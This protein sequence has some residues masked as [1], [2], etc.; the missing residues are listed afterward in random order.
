MKFE[1]KILRNKAYL[2]S[3]LLFHITCTYNHITCH[4]PTWHAFPHYMPL[5]HSTCHFPTSQAPSPHGMPFLTLHALSPPHV[6]PSTPRSKADQVFAEHPTGARLHPTGARLQAT[7]QRL[8]ATGTRLQATGARLQATWPQLQAITLVWWTT[9]I[10]D[11]GL[12]VDNNT[13]H[14]YCNRIIAY[15]NN[16]W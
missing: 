1:E 11:N 9:I 2:C 8:Q 7:G 3:D 12:N 6:P 13:Y 14:S 5:P 4:F 16:Y 15:Y 10:I